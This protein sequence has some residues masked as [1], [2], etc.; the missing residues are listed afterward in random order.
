VSRALYVLGGPLIWLA[1]L[2]LLLGIGAQGCAGSGL[3]LAIQLLAVA[4]CVAIL[5]RALTAVRT[6]SLAGNDQARLLHFFAGGLAVL[7]MVAIGASALA[8]SYA[9][10]C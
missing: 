9:A 7:A 3:V 2:L 10:S 6:P 8:T 5:Y 4:G 1:S